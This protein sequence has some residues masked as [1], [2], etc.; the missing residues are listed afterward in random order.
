[1]RGRGAGYWQRPVVSSRTNPSRHVQVPSSSQVPCSEETAGSRLH[2]WSWPGVQ[3]GGGE[4]SQAAIQATKATVPG[5]YVLRVTGDCLPLK[6]WLEVV[7][8]SVPEA[9][10]H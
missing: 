5:H 8:A 6:R 4:A 3:A 2:V 10:P 1:M 7:P 9:Q